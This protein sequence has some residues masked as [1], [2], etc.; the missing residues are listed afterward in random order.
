[1]RWA[2]AGATTIEV[3][4]LAQVRVGNRRRRVAVERR[5]RGFTGEGREGD[6]THETSGVG[7]ENR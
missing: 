7:G 2:V 4:V 6:R 5:A 1:M 3:G